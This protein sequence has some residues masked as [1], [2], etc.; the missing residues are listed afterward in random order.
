MGQRILY[1][2]THFPFNYLLERAVGIRAFNF[3]INDDVLTRVVRV[4][5]GD[6][7]N[8]AHAICLSIVKNSGD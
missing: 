3:V 4:R 8:G 2:L 1:S 7:R 5:N 6:F